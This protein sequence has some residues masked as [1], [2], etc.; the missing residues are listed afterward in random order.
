MVPI[1]RLINQRNGI[2]TA[3]PENDGA[4]RHALSSFDFRV[5]RGIV[6]HR[7]GKAAV[8]VRGFFFRLRRPIVPAPIDRVRRR[9]TILAFPPD[10]ATIGECDIGVKRIA[11]D[12]FHRVWVR[13]IAGAGHDAEVAILRVDRVKPS[14]A[15]LHPSD[16]VADRCDF[17]ALEMLRWNQHRK[18]C[19]AACTGEGRGHIMF[20]SFGRFNTEDQHVLCHPALLAREI[21]TDAQSKTFFAKQNVPTVSGTN[22]DDRVVLRKMTDKPPCRI[23][24]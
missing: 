5:E 10:V 22:G 14:V 2:A 19:F 8:G 13:F 3:S 6:A 21:G 16:V 18:I 11:R 17:P 15:N 4:N 9:G 20:F 24:I 23:D 7:R 1:Q 12:R